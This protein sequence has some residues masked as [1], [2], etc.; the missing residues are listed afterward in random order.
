MESAMPLAPPSRRRAPLAGLGL[1]ALLFLAGCTPGGGGGLSGT[2]EAKDG[3][4]GMT[5]VFKSG[6]KVQV[7]TQQGGGQ[8]E[9]SEGDFMVN[10]NQITVQI[11]GGMPLQLTRNGK[12]LDASMMGQIL[13]FT[14]K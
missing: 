2:Y 10:G 13:H 3:E 14:R 4:N 6:G 9:V 12:T 7:T 11:P 5:L 8:P 1:A